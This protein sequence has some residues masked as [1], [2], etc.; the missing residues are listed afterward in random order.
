LAFAKL[1]PDIGHATCEQFAQGEE[2]PGIQR[3]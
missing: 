2:R 3:Y 1:L